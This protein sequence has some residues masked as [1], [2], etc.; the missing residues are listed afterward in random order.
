MPELKVRLRSA[1]TQDDFRACRGVC[2]AVPDTG[3]TRS[4]VGASVLDSAGISYDPAGAERVTTANGDIMKCLGNVLLDMDIEGTCL[5]VDALVA[6]RLHSDLLIS[7]QD[8]QR[9][10]IISPSFLFCRITARA[11]AASSNFGVRVSILFQKIP[12]RTTPS[13]MVWLNQL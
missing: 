12:A 9:F 13:R 4:I 2:S 11:S 5:V 10:G 3:T 6:Q 1:C 7:W 8:L